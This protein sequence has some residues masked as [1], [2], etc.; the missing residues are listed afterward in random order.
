MRKVGTMR[1]DSLMLLLPEVPVLGQGDNVRVAL[2]QM[3]RHHLG[4]ACIVD[5]EGRLQSVLTDGDVRRTLLQLQKPVSALLADEASRHGTSNVTTVAPHTA[6][7]DAVAKMG[8]LGVWDLPVVELD[9]QLIGVLHLHP[10]V[11]ELI[12]MMDGRG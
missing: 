11:Q 4:L 7:R 6:L 10:V 5:A 3:T 1:V 2:E 12:Q 9:G 8:E